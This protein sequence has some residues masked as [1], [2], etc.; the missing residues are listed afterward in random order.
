MY[1]C[2]HPPV[3]CHSCTDSLGDHWER[4]PNIHVQS[5]RF[6]DSHDAKTS[7]GPLNVMHRETS[8]LVH[9]PSARRDPGI[10]LY[11]S[12]IHGTKNVN[13]RKQTSCFASSIVMS[14]IM[15]CSHC[16]LALSRFAFVDTCVY[17]LMTLYCLYVASV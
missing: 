11:G 4:C 7:L 12:I 14:I 13:M 5:G 17:V 1:V 16:L 6:G 3:N 8:R 10:V 15:E 2:V 9:I